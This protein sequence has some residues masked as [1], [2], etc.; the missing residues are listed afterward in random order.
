MVNL[1]VGFL[2]LGGATIGSGIADFEFIIEENGVVVDDVSNVQGLFHRCEIFFGSISPVA[3]T[4]LYVVGAELLGCADSA[5]D[6]NY[7]GFATTRNEPG[8]DET[9][10]FMMTSDDYSF[11]SDFQ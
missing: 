8:T 2:S 5:V 3:A 11:S 7:T 10:V 4:N 9:L 1:L 6:M